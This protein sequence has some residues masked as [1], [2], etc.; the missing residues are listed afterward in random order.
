[1][2]KQHT[3]TQ[4]NMSNLPNNSHHI[5]LW[6]EQGYIQLT[7]KS[8]FWLHIWSVMIWQQKLYQFKESRTRNK[9]EELLIP[10][11][12]RWIHR[13]PGMGFLLRTLYWPFGFHTL[14]ESKL[15]IF[16][17]RLPEIPKTNKFVLLLLSGK[18]LN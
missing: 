13:V 9:P 2:K 5:C 17:Y 10:V 11:E 14:V 7:I 15:A 18:Y 16:S 3:I 4:K 12:S 6:Y 1:M 8:F